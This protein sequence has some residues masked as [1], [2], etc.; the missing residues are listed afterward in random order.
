MSTPLNT[1]L[2]RDI[3]AALAQIQEDV[4]EEHKLEQRLYQA[5]LQEKSVTS[6]GML[7]AQRQEQHSKRLDGEEKE[8]DLEQK[9]MKGIWEESKTRHA[10]SLEQAHRLT[11]RSEFILRGGA[12]RGIR[13]ETFYE[14]AYHETYYIILQPPGPKARS[15]G[16]SWRVHRHTLPSF[17]PIRQLGKAW[18]RKNEQRLWM[19]VDE[20]LQA[21]VSRREQ[22]KA[23]KSSNVLNEWWSVQDIQAD[24]SLS[25][26]TLMLCPM[27]ST[28]SIPSIMVRLMYEDKKILQRVITI[29]FDK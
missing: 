11:G 10:L 14:G 25:F 21:Y 12:M 13:L 17:I 26:A 19:E 5:T 28:L 9:M 8:A 22:L 7:L 16:I 15:K 18:L 24:T 4:R 23:L 29:D 3:P 1:R 20:L 6:I 2:S 27:R